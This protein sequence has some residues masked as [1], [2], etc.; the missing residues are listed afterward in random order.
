MFN[1]RENNDKK[2][3]NDIA[4]S[5]VKKDLT[6]YCRIARKQRL[7]RSIE[8]IKKPIRNLLEVGCGAGFSAEYLKG[9]F[10]NYVGVDYSQNL[11]NYALEHNN[12]QRVKF[13]CLN[14]NE[15]YSKLKFDVIL[16]IGVLHHMPEPENIIQLLEKNLARRYYCRQR[17]SSWN[18]FIGL[19]RKIR[20]KI[21][22]DYSS[23]QVEFTENQI[24]S[25]FEKN[26]FNVTTYAQG[27]LSTPLAESR[28][29]PGFIGIPLVLISSILDPILE[30]LFSILNIKK[31]TWNVIVHARQKG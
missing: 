1:N 20:K 9:N 30:K 16:M 29:L 27:I 12:H 7:V 14:I 5:Y 26:G 15:F 23:D 18:P 24:R 21:D 17:T 6:L 11:I 4:T 3:F 31:L 25:I 28:I 22:N 19:L 8:G 10:I 13:E 2:L